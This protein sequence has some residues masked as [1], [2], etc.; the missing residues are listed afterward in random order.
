MANTYS[1]IY[2]HI[3]F[4]VMARSNLINKNFREELHKYI[5]GIIKRRGQKLLTI[6]SVSNHIH[7]LCNTQPDCNISDLVR[8]V[9]SYSTK[10]INNKRWLNV[11]FYW[12]RGFGAFSYSQSQVDTI[13]H[14]I[15]NQEK[16]H[17]TK[18]YRTEYLEFLK[19]FEIEFDPR[20]V[21]D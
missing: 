7:L 8:D 2:I 4:S 11:K 10:F 21:F 6:N 3:V 1:K 19:K 17:K 20:Y 5:S 15:Q 12:Q 9:K 14:Y 18:S 13:I 16:H